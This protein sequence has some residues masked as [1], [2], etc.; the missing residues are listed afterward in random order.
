MTHG[1]GGLRGWAISE[2]CLTRIE[3]DVRLN[4]VGLAN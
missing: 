2:S 1:S 4:P 3:V